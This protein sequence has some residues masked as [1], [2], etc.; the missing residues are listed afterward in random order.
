MFKRAMM[1]QLNQ[2]K[3]GTHRNYPSLWLTNAL[4]QTSTTSNVQP[5]LS[6]N[7]KCWNDPLGSTFFSTVPDLQSDVACVFLKFSGFFKKAEPQASV[8]VLENVD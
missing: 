2:C 3:H 4:T 7:L 5:F 8:E 1:S 6:N